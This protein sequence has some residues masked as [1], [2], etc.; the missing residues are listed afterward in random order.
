VS[1]RLPV[2]SVVVAGA[3]AMRRCPVV[4]S[5]IGARRLSPGRF[6]V[7]VCGSRDDRGHN[8]HREYDDGLR[9]RGEGGTREESEWGMRG[10]WC[11]GSAARRLRRCA[12]ARRGGHLFETI[13]VQRVVG[14]GAA[15]S[16]PCAMDE[17]GLH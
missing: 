6:L 11:A 8:L 12:C 5:D 1:E 16:V 4:Q 9:H 13:T 17:L 14:G 10:R 3:R 2:I 7:I 15:C